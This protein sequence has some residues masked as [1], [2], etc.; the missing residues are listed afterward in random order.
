MIKQKIRTASTP[1]VQ[2]PYSPAHDTQETS[3]DSGLAQSQGLSHRLD[4]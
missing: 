3:T 4:E 1:K 2:K